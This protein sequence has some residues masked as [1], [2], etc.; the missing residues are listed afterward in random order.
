MLTFFEFL[1]KLINEQTE[2]SFL[3][4]K[5]FYI[6]RRDSKGK[7]EYAVAANAKTDS[8]WKSVDEALERA[9]PEFKDVLWAAIH[10]LEREER[11]TRIPTFLG[12]KNGQSA[13]SMSLR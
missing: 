8:A 3:S 6:I 11:S 4:G 7:L 12:Q 5:T 10:K 13:F 9:T 2:T 1:E